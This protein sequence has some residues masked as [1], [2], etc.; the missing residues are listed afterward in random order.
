MSQEILSWKTCKH[1]E[2]SG[3][4]M[5]LNADGLCDN[6]NKILSSRI[7]RAVQVISKT[8]DTIDSA[9]RLK[10][11]LTQL[12]IIEDVVRKHILPLEEKGIKATNQT[13]SEIL[14]QTKNWRDEI[15]SEN[16]KELMSNTKIKIE[17]AGT[18]ELK[19]NVYSEVLKEIA[20]LKDL[21]DKVSNS[22]IISDFENK[23]KQQI[24]DIKQNTFHAAAGTT[25]NQTIIVSDLNQKERIPEFSVHAT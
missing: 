9:K 20:A 21:K 6:C 18:E 11:K 3:W 14:G 24:D 16:L 7:K 4:L 12:G 15:I 25:E 5:S 1:C 22:D 23:V 10:T 8:V 13:S 2:K 19:I 17:K